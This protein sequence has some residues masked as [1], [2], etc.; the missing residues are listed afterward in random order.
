M[1]HPGEFWAVLSFLT[2]KKYLIKILQQPYKQVSFKG[3]H[4]PSN[5]L[6]QS[7]DKIKPLWNATQIILKQSYFPTQ[8]L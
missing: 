7:S 8:T 6:F 1:Q 4:L 5:S 2:L 3:F